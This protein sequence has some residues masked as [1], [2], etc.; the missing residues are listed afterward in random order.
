M[1]I[2]EVSSDG[3]KQAKINQNDTNQKAGRKGDRSENISAT[4]DVLEHGRRST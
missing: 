2:S 4:G 1:R 3:K